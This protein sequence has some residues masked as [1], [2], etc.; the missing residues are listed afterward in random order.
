MSEPSPTPPESG[1]FHLDWRVARRFAHFAGSFWTGPTGRGAWTLTLALAASLLLS[2]FVTVLMNQWNRWFFDALERR[3]VAGLKQAVLVFFG[4]V[5]FMAAIGVAI[6]IARMTLQVRWRQWLVEHLIGKWLESQKFYH[7]NASGRE[8]PNPE[9]RIS[10]DTRWATEVLVDLGIGLFTAIMGGIAFITILWTVGGSFGVGSIVVPGY[11][12]WC[13]LGYGIAASTLTAWVGRPLVG[14]VGQKN[15][16]EG[17]FRFAMMRLRDNAESIALAH[18]APAEQKILRGFYDTVVGRWLAIVRSNAHLTWITNAT[19]PMI[20]IVPLLFATPKYLAGDLT[21]GQVTQLAAAFIQVQQAISWIV[22]NYSRIADWYAS[23]RRVMDIVDASDAIAPDLPAERAA[24]P[25]AP[26][27]ALSLDRVTLHAADGH[28]LLL[29]VTL[30]LKRGEAVHIAGA[31]N[32]GKSTLARILAGLVVPSSGNLTGLP[33]ASILLLPQKSYLPLGT[34]GEAIAYPHVGSLPPRSALVDALEIVGLPA[35]PT[36][37]TEHAR[38]DQVLSA[39]DR[40]RLAAARAVI[41]KP[42][43]LVIDDALSALDGAGQRA[44]IQRL[45]SALPGITI[46]SLGQRAAPANTFDR[47]LELTRL[48]HEAMLARAVL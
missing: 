5:A 18:G 21:L 19:G 25:L 11:M 13:A 40:Q 16:A 3:D 37:L 9:Y 10:D 44:L 7:L 43:I 42:D 15:E 14:R 47:T 26:K 32:T 1:G 31:S 36:R 35:L 2:T 48:D 24:E 45:R 17:Y 39:G 23:A 28:P 34:L 12:V 41:A 22:D 46:L 8:P 6:V 30:E 27:L 4:I 38:W 33:P 29:P 20:P